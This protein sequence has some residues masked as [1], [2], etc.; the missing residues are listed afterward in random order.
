M[1]ILVQNAIQN[2]GGI[3][4]I[5]HTARS[6]GGGDSSDDL[7]ETSILTYNKICYCTTYGVHTE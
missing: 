4:N 6:V 3:R 7:L 5:Q 1:G 2:M